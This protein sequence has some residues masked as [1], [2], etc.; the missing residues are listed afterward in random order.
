[1]TEGLQIGWPA[2]LV[3]P[4]T[5]AAHRSETRLPRNKPHARALLGRASSYPSSSREACLRLSHATRLA[6]RLSCSSVDLGRPPRPAT[7]ASDPGQ[8]LAGVLQRIPKE[9]RAVGADSQEVYRVCAEPDIETDWSPKVVFFGRGCSGR[10]SL[11]VAGLFLIAN[12]NTYDQPIQR[13]FIRP[14]AKSQYRVAA[15][16]GCCTRISRRSSRAQRALRE[17]RAGYLPASGWPLAGQGVGDARILRGVRACQTWYLAH[18][19]QRLGASRATSIEA[20]VVTRG[21]HRRPVGPVSPGTRAAG[22]LETKRVWNEPQH[23][24][25]MG[26]FLPALCLSWQH[27]SARFTPPDRSSVFLIVQIFGAWSCAGGSWDAHQWDRSWHLPSYFG[28]AVSRRTVTGLCEESGWRP[29]RS[30]TLHNNHMRLNH[31]DYGGL[32]TYP[33]PCKCGKHKY[34]RG[35]PSGLTHRPEEPCPFKDD[36][37]PISIFGSCCWLRSFIAVMKPN[38]LPKI[39]PKSQQA[40]T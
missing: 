15:H 25:C 2:G 19:S 35:I 34:G 3:S 21:L 7:S 24:H 5:R 23:R 14:K 27:R 13:R 37:F 29:G 6:F 30:L 11:C 12:A 8:P 32:D 4:A 38:V 40:T 17:D 33:V 20:E 16:R 9:V 28:T 36:G 10:S 39:P 1:M 18:Q 22:R 26:E 31:Y